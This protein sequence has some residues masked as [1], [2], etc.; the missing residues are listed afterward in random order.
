MCPFCLS[1]LAW[2]AVGGSAAATGTLLAAW[3]KKG[4]DDGDERYDSSDGDA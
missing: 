4:K 1:T 3:H 2:L